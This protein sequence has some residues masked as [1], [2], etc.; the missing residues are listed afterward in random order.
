[1]DYTKLVTGFPDFVLADFYVDGITDRVFHL[2]VEDTH[3]DE[4]Y[5]FHF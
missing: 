4:M 5:L 1:M 3:D 2:S